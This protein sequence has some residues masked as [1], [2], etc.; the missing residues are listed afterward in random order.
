MEAGED[1]VVNAGTSKNRNW[2]CKAQELFNFMLSWFDVARQTGICL[3]RCWRRVSS[4]WIKVKWSYYLYTRMC[5]VPSFQSDLGKY[6]KVRCKLIHV[7]LQFL[8][9]RI[10]DTH[11]RMLQWQCRDLT[12]W[13]LI[14]SNI[15]AWLLESFNIFDFLNHSYTRNLTFLPCV[16]VDMYLQGTRSNE[17]LLANSAS[18]PFLVP[19]W[20]SHVK[21]T[22]HWFRCWR[23]RRGKYGGEFWK[24]L[25]GDSG[26]V[27]GWV[28]SIEAESAHVLLLWGTRSNTTLIIDGIVWERISGYWGAESNAWK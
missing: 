23:K 4:K 11:S 22:H 3:T 14:C 28:C 1:D 7:S 16:T 10:Y 8:I 18:V 25:L 2:V 15:V 13:N 5:G 20:L 27:E 9:Q 24:T 17:P 21:V 12:G 6:L 26:C 19:W